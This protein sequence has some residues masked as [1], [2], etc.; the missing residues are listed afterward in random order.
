MMLTTPF[1][2]DQVMDP[3]KTKLDIRSLICPFPPGCHR[4]DTAVPSR[5]EKH[6]KPGTKKAPT[7]SAACRIGF[8]FQLPS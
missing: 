7:I 4:G 2:S 5:G 1:P 6:L 3:Q 8:C